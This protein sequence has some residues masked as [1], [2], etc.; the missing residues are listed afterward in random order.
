MISI[1]IPT[2][3]E[4]KVIG[5]TLR[6]LKSRLTIPHEIIV[7]DGKSTDKTV[8][9]ARGIADKVVEYTGTTRQTIAQ[10][11]NDGAKSAQ[12]EYIAFMDADCSFHDPDIFFG[13]LVKH[14]ESNPDIVAA[15]TAIRVEKQFETLADWLVYTIFNFVL[16]FNNNILNKGQAAGEFQFI[17]ASAFNK[18]G[19]FNES[20]V[21]AEDFDLFDRLA[22]VGRIRFEYSLTVYHSGRRAHKIGWIKLLKQWNK[23]YLSVKK[24]GKAHSEEWTVIR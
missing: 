6:N 12:G 23:N 1:I 20:L 21:A 16:W 14:F 19:G 3:N 18:V 10:G 4:E 7:T 15:V 13:S 17:R 22:K 11:R 9:I 5:R 2:L 8:E 24:H